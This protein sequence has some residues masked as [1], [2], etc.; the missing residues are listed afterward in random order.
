MEVVDVQGIIKKLRA[1]ASIGKEYHN[2]RKIKIRRNIDPLLYKYDTRQMTV[3][4]IVSK[5]F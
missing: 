5:E 3:E 1:A 4:Q 2:A